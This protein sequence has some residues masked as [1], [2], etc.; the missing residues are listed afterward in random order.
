MCGRFV[1]S[2]STAD[3]V[4]ELSEA[5]T[6][7]HLSMDMDGA[8][9]ESFQNFNT[10]PTHH[11]PV[12]R[13]VDG[14]VVMEEMQWGLVPVWSKDPGVGSKMINARSETVTE[15]PSF[16]G[17]VQKH[18]CIVPMSG[19]YEW[20]RSDPKH[21]IPYFVTRADGHLMLAAGLWTRSPALADQHTF[22]MITRESVEDLSHIHNRCLV[23]FNAKEAIDWLA[24]PQ[25]PLELFEPSHQPRLATLRVST[26]VNSVMNNDP[27]LID[28]DTSAVV[29]SEPVQDTLF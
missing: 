9:E 14:R 11:V 26:R 22:T 28:G 17:L 3:V 12:L 10:A 6:A 25:A 20:D 2:F 21:K 8:P 29:V 27:S 5:V 18:R 19:F 7:A 24:E 1:G 13:L 23:E 4:A 15:K 16:R